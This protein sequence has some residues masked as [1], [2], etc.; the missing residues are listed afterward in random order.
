MYLSDIKADSNATPAEIERH[1]RRRMGYLLL[2]VVGLLLLF[3]VMRLWW[4]GSDA[5]P[6]P[7]PVVTVAKPL[8]R[9]V[10]DWDDYVGRF[11]AS[12]EIE[13]RPRV[14]GQLVGIHFKDGDIVQRGQLLFTIDPRPFEA[15]L[16]EV[17]ARV[18][19]AS[20]ALTLARSELARASRL[21]P[22]QAVSAEEIDSLKARV[23]SAQAQL[24]AAQAQVRSR[25][26]NVEFAHIRA[27]VTGRISDRRVDI[28]NLVA[29]DS[30]ANA[31]VLTTIN[32]LDP[33]YFVFDGSEALYLKQR[34]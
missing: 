6:P 1:R 11:K 31:T 8:S 18:A 10:T 9:M 15:E 22:D 26:L 33:I 5:A 14:S 20:T 34:R 16:A 17:Q 19:S 25:Q 21:I 7:P 24:A 29:G 2:P 32:A 4:G 12:Q 23:Q 3:A 28:N 30:A 13:I 27:P